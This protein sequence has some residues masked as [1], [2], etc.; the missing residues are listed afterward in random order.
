MQ[1]SLL[2][3]CLLV[4]LWVPLLVFSSSNPAFKT[5]DLSQFAFNVTLVHV[6]TQRSGMT[7]TLRAPLYASTL[8]YAIQP[9]QRNGTVLPPSLAAYSDRQLQLHCAAT[10]A[11]A[12]WTVT[13]PLRDHWLRVLNDCLAPGDPALTPGD[14]VLTPGD[15]AFTPTNTTT[16]QDLRPSSRALRAATPV[17]ALGPRDIPTNQHA[18]LLRAAT[19]SQATISQATVSQANVSQANASQTSVSQATVSQASVSQ[20]NVSRANASQAN[21]SLAN[22]SQENVSQANMSQAKVS[23]ASV[24]QHPHWLPASPLPRAANASLVQLELAWTTMRSFPPVSAYGGPLCEGTSLVDLAP[25]S[26]A[27]LRDVMTGAAEWAPL[28]GR[29]HPHPG[30]RAPVNGGPLGRSGDPGETGNRGEIGDQGKR[31]RAGIFSFVWR[32]KGHKCNVSPMWSSEAVNGLTDA[33]LASPS[34]WAAYQV[35]GLLRLLLSLY[36]SRS[37]ADVVRPTL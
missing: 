36:D 31:D 15:P 26:V 35:R 8:D 7:A 9:W 16:A 5:P 4:L 11:D 30:P 3:G 14:P 10:D 18:S 28:R 19:V 21:V 13:P 32:L 20:A 12:Y 23:R 17:R 22:V 34:G 29:P 37:D 1:G 2:V 27:A 25:E 24:S 6:S 33:E